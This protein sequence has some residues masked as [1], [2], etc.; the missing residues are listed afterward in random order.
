MAD[1]LRVVNWKRYQHYRKPRPIWIKLYRELLDD[2]DFNC[3]SDAARSHLMSIWMLAAACGN[4]LRNDARW[5]GGKISATTRVNLDE[6]ILRGFLEPYTMS[7][8]S[9]ED[10][11]TDPSAL[12]SETEIEIEKRK[13]MMSEPKP[14]S[15][16]LSDQ[17]I[18]AEFY[19]VLCGLILKEHPA[20]RIPTAGT[21]GEHK[22]RE[23]LEKLARLDRFV[24][25]D[26][27][28]CLTWLFESP[29]ERA[30]FWRQQVHGVAPLRVAKS[31]ATKF[32]KIH[33]AFVGARRG[34]KAKP[35]DATLPLR[36]RLRALCRALDG[37]QY[38]S[39]SDA[40]R[41]RRVN[42]TPDEITAYER[43]LAAKP[44]RRPARQRRTDCEKPRGLDALVGAALEHVQMG[45]GK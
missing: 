39:M 35:T 17:P 31:G 4:K 22:A 13:S 11:Y 25:A 21:Q 5:V 41:Y 34:T 43:E 9:L 27:V 42:A 8:D 45:D 23:A 15:D 30:V 26:M 33:E 20:A 36:E 16:P 40:D 28:A 24:P 2:D 18:L 44:P 12:R 6:L 7:R 29:D 19:P 10:V 14:V 1:Y 37:A 32:A 38:A 3:L